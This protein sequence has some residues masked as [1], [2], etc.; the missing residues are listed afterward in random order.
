M[1]ISN[2]AV[3]IFGFGLSTYLCLVF[4]LIAIAKMNPLIISITY[5]IQPIIA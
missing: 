5:I 3:G 4:V 2:L 1:I